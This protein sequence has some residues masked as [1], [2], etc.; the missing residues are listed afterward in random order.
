MI[1]R[2]RRRR[3]LR[4][5][6]VLEQSLGLWPPWELIVEWGYEFTSYRSATMSDLEHPPPWAK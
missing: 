4:R 1:R 6:A 2:W 5:I 3:C